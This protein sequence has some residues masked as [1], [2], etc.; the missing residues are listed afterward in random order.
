MRILNVISSVDPAGGGPI[1]SVLQTARA[2]DA[3]GHHSEI[4][5][6]DAPGAP[7]LDDVPL[8]VHAR[9][10]AHSVYRY[11][12]RFVTWLRRHA[13]DYDVVIVH[14]LWQFHGLAVWRALRHS[15]T[16]YFVFPHGMLDPWFKR[17]Y[18]L[19]H[20]KKCLYW[21]W[22]EYRVLRDARA[23]C[24]TCEEERVLARQSFRFYRARE[25]VVA[26]GTARP[27]AEESAQNAA[28]LEQ[29]PHLRGR[30]F[31]LFLS[32]IHPKK[33]CDILLEA[34]AQAT[35]Q[36]PDWHL[37]LAGPDQRG[38]QTTLQEQARSLGIEER[39]TWTG[40]LSGAAKWGAFRSAQAFVLPSHQENFG[41]AVAEALACRLP[42]LISDKINIW[43][44]I[45]NDGA[46][47]VAS[48]TLEDTRELLQQWLALSPAAQN[49]MREK[50][51]HCFET[52]FEIQRAAQE[53][54][55]VLAGRV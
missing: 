30:P 13:T 12:P 36:H 10:P 5:A 43:R 39:V 28:F 42:V 52:R 20:F 35:A 9:G 4:V 15:R 40:M 7:F 54:L 16:P 44:E 34:F 31:F 38:W 3:L 47:L 23:V 46:G 25:R 27:P 11:A 2:L 50:A 24:F 49:A 29:F 45:H 18:P 55:Q 32:R 41:I 37:V 19:K 1:E 21:P 33:G 8:I 22:G 6:L 51:L 48:D 14:G 26:F 53:L 17:T